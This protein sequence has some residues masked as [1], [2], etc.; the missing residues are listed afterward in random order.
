M[1]LKHF[2]QPVHEC[3]E[4]EAQHYDP[5]HRTD[6]AGQHEED[7]GGVK[8]YPESLQELW[9]VRYYWV[10]KDYQVSINTF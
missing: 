8:S 7:D 9:Y 4:Y 10:T 6:H 1:T 2:N 5:E 3:Q